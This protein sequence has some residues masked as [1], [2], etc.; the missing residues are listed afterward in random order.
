MIQQACHLLSTSFTHTNTCLVHYHSLHF[1]MTRMANLLTETAPSPELNLNGGEGERMKRRRRRVYQTSR[2]PLYV[3]CSLSVCVYVHECVL[4]E[5]VLGSFQC[6]Y[7]HTSFRARELL[8]VVK[9][10]KR[11]TRERFSYKLCS[12]FGMQMS[13]SKF[14]N[15]IRKSMMRIQSFPREFSSQGVKNVSLTELNV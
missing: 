14:F 10:L 7:V 12:C 6:V 1:T 13:V 8:F 2:C 9:Y 4:D 15:S 11:R 5:C 3:Y